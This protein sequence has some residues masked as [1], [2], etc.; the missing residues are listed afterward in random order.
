MLHHL[1][2][3]IFPAPCSRANPAGRG[4]RAVRHSEPPVDRVAGAAGGVLLFDMAEV[5]E[6]VELR[7]R[8]A[9]AA[10]GRA[11]TRPPTAG[12]GE[13]ARRGGCEAYGSRSV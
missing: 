5:A 2:N 12:A 13:R 10:S 3:P 6:G 9:G 4:G 7:C 8:A 11:A 1:H